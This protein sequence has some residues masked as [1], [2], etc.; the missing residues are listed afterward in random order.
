MN[1]D[2]DPDPYREPWCTLCSDDQTIET[3]D[4]SRAPCP[5]CCPSP[6][7]MA[8]NAAEYQQRVAAGLEKEGDPF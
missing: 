6:E 7:Q 2:L 5:D 3:E 8:I 1:S 4:G